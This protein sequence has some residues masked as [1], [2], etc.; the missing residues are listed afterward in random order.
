MFVAYIRS[1]AVYYSYGQFPN[2]TQN[3]AVLCARLDRAL[4]EFGTIP[5]YAVGDILEDA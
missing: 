5:R 3:I 1:M 4:D 2:N